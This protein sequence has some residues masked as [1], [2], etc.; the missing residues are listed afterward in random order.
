MIN[1]HYYLVIAWCLASSTVN[2]DEQLKIAIAPLTFAD[3]SELFLASES[4]T[5]LDLPTMYQLKSRIKQI[6]FNQSESLLT[7]FITDNNFKYVIPQTESANYCL[8]GKVTR[9]I[10]GQSTTAINQSSYH[11]NIYHI[12]MLIDYQILNES[13]NRNNVVKFTVQAKSG[14][15]NLALAN[16]VIN[17]NSNQLIEQSLNNL[18]EQIHYWLHYQLNQ[19]KLTLIN[20]SDLITSK[21]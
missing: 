8:V 20:E 7:K 21:G 12:Q 18:F 16:S 1:K 4:S 2:A 5:K 14:V 11:S 17:I 6:T 15:A 9:I 10:A 3:E 13:T 19:G